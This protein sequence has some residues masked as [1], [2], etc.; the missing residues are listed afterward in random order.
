MA[1]FEDLATRRAALELQL[2]R[3]GRQQRKRVFD[4]IERIDALRNGTASSALVFDSELCKSLLRDWAW[5]RKS[6]AQVQALAHLAYTD[7]QQLLRR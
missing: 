5:S 3:G 4:E 6:A 1:G 2:N 7:E